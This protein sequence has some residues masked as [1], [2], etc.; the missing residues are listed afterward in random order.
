M[1][2]YTMIFF[3]AHLI[4]GFVASGVAYYERFLQSLKIDEFVA[5]YS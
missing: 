3:P 2:F 5:F 1:S 4:H